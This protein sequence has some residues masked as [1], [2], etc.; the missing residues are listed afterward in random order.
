LYV[1]E[2]PIELRSS[3]PSRF[4]VVPGLCRF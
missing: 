1:P 4:R 2:R 3:A